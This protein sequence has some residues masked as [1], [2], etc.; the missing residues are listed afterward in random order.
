MSQKNLEKQQHFFELEEQRAKQQERINK[1][2]K[3]GLQR[4]GIAKLSV[5]NLK[6]PKINLK[7][8]PSSLKTVVSAR[9]AKKT[10]TEISES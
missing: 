8:C 7:S 6:L 2:V 3:S 9:A 5:P 10:V 4:L 1:N